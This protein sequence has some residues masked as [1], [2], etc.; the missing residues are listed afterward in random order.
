MTTGYL[1]LLVSGGWRVQGYCQASQRTWDRPPH[2]KES[3]GSKCQE[4]VNCR[5]VSWASSFL[6]LKDFL[7]SLRQ[8]LNRR[9]LEG[10]YLLNPHPLGNFLFPLRKRETKVLS[11]VK[12]SEPFTQCPFFPISFGA[13][14]GVKYFLEQEMH[15][16]NPPEGM[17]LAHPWEFSLLHP[18]TPT[19]GE[20]RT[21]TSKG[22]RVL[23]WS[24][25]L[26]YLWILSFYL[27]NAYEFFLLCHIYIN[28]I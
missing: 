26:T 7:G 22:M 23:A 3:T 15:G 2:N 28:F 25:P 14:S 9:K 4:N 5:L 20:E 11:E 12:F 10:S 17:G 24:R 6:N 27:K 21:C 13:A 19:R 8:G 16:W 1:V 18:W